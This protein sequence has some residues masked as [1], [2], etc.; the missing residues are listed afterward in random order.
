MLLVL[1]RSPHKGMYFAAIRL[2]LLFVSISHRSDCRIRVCISH[3][4]HYSIWIS[5]RNHNVWIFFF[6]R[7]WCYGIRGPCTKNDINQKFLTHLISVMICGFRK[8]PVDWGL[9]YRYIKGLESTCCIIFKFKGVLS[10]PFLT[11]QAPNNLLPS[12]SGKQR[13]NILVLLVLVCFPCQLVFINHFDKV[14][15]L[16]YN[17]LTL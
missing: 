17:T 7:T 1:I 16:W 10:A 8:N 13:S 15:L 9:V 11:T 4:S 3:Q 14:L 12:R 2:S 6:S 5:C